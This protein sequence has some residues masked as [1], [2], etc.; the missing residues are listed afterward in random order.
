MRRRFRRDESEDLVRLLENADVRQE[1]ARVLLREPRGA[2]DVLRR[3]GG[4]A[5]HPRREPRIFFA[6]RS[7]RSLGLL[8]R[9]RGRLRL[10]ARFLRRRGRDRVLL[11][12]RGELGRVR[13]ALLE[14]PALQRGDLLARA[15]RRL[16]R[17]RR[18]RGG[19]LLRG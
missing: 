17:R 14:D 12:K 13:V 11:S 15:R 3:V 5:T 6:L 2:D 9:L 16:F 4:S 8:L 1:R 19:R 18:G 10:R 7:A